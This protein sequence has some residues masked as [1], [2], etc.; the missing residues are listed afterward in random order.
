MEIIESIIF[1]LAIGLLLMLVTVKK[2]KKRYLVISQVITIILGI[3]YLIY[4]AILWQLYPL[5]LAIFLMTFLVLLTLFSADL[6]HRF[7]KTRTV[8]FMFLILL[9]IIS[10]G[11]KYAFPIYEIPS[12]TG[13][14]SIGTESFVL[15]D[16]T[17]EELYGSEDKRKIKIQI[18]YP[19]E[20]TQAYALVPWLEDGQI[21]ARGLAKDT[22][23]PYFVLDHTALIM[24]NSYDE[25]PISHSLEQY[26]V[27]VISHGW[28]GFRNIHTDLAEELA[29]SGYIVISIDH[30]YGSV[31]TVFSDDDIA[32][33]NLDALP[34]STDKTEFL[35]YANTLVNTYAGDI[36]QTL[37]YLEKVNLGEVKSQFEGKLDLTSIGLMGHSTG[38]GANVAVALSDTRIKA[39][40]GMDA[41]V[42]PIYTDEI[43]KGLDIPAVF[44]RSESWETGINNVNL[45]SLVNSNI[46]NIQLFQIE[47]T[48]HYD[49]SMAY[50]YSPLTKPLGMTG[51]LNGDEIVEI[52][53]NMMTDF[54][55][56]TL[57]ETSTF[58]PIIIETPWTEV[59]EVN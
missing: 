46:E 18:W 51:E 38:G 27:V 44:L 35:V 59:I 34:S 14:Y 7:R 55:N 11:L 24:S 45:M 33:V 3:L 54:F 15:V 25:A 23:L 40:F 20:E 29:S 42:E 58:D 47:G 17:R 1:L 19:T 5:Y 52:L 16:E 39:I 26:P 43:D 56:Q 41:W 4:G 48:T 22:G 37:D 13:L 36:V 50:M 31:A 30:T 2:I 8:F 21:V 32:F 53:T 49:F 10:V 57:K 28:R 9:I 12:P 6:V